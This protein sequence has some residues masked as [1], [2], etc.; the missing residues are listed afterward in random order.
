MPRPTKAPEEDQGKNFNFRMGTPMWKEINDEAV[1]QTAASG[2]KH[3]ATDM[4]RIAW[5]FY[6]EWR[7]KKPKLRK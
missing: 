3:S 7:N 1:A 4:L 5:K 2:I 6:M